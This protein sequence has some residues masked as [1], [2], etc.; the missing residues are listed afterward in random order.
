MALFNS[1]AVPEWETTL[2]TIN[3]TDKKR[4]KAMQAEIALLRTAK[5]GLEVSLAEAKD[6]LEEIKSALAKQSLV[7]DDELFM[8]IKKS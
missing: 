4:M 6:D 5:H 3:I 2:G 1:I 8:Y 7:W